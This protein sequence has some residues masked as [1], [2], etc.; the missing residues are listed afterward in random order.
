M[1]SVLCSCLGPS[2]GQGGPPRPLWNLALDLC[3]LFL[4]SNVP[5]HISWTQNEPSLKHKF[6]RTLVFH[7]IPWLCV[8]SS[9]HILCFHSPSMNSIILLRDVDLTQITPLT[10]EHIRREIL[11]AAYLAGRHSLRKRD[12]EEIYF[13]F[14]AYFFSSSSS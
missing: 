13:L 10:R 1:C 8:H 6:C 2:Q 3:L 5:L 7:R 4:S 11:Q 12:A 9:S 14:N